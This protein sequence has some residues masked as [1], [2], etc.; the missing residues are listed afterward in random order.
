MGHGLADSAGV[1]GC[2][3]VDPGEATDVV[4][5]RTAGTARTRRAVESRGCVGNLAA[6]EPSWT[7]P[8]GN[9]RSGR[10]PTRPSPHRVRIA[11]PPRGEF[12]IFVMTVADQNA[13]S[14]ISGLKL[15]VDLRIALHHRLVLVAQRQTGAPRV[16]GASV[17]C[18]NCPRLR[19][20]PA[21]SAHPSQH[22]CQA[23]RRAGSQAEL[24]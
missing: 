24:P 14:S 2:H 12:V 23:D 18:G 8:S 11:C 15:A 6:S 17:L 4:D 22:R 5:R 9:D 21:A 13:S 19:G 20:S 7:R 10:S 16:V 1:V 3:V